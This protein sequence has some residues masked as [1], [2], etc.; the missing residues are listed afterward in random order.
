MV[1]EQV[2]TF[3]IQDNLNIVCT[4]I[5][6]AAMDIVEKAAAPQISASAS[7]TAPQTTLNQYPKPPEVCPLATI[8]KLNANLCKQPTLTPTGTK[9]DLAEKAAAPQISI[10][11]SQ[12]T[13]QA[14]LHQCNKPSDVRFLLS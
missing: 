2:V 1:P 10:S 14:T 5:E 12:T 4:A 11:Q 8:Y 9:R 7:Q 6:K 13:A 3:L